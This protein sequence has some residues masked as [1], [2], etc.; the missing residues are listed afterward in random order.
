VVGNSFGAAVSYCLATEAPARCRG[1]VL[2][3]GG[4]VPSLPT[5]LRA[6]LGSAPAARLLTSLVHRLAHGPAA[7][8]RAFADPGRAPAELVSLLAGRA[9]E[10]RRTVELLTSMLRVPAPALPPPACPVLLLW[11]ADD[12][13]AGTGADAAAKLRQK[14]PGAELVLIGR[15]GHFPQLE[16]PER[17]VAELE[18]FTAR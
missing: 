2:V 18:R 3:N 11:G 12:Q 8:T 10:G 4:P 15:A 16:Q 6:L 14:L 9:G 1:L 17:F 5:P 13:L 7:L